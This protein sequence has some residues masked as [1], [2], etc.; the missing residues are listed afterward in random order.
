MRLPENSGWIFQNFKNYKKILSEL[1]DIGLRSWVPWQLRISRVQKEQKIVYFH[2]RGSAGT[3]DV[4]NYSKIIPHVTLIGILC[5]WMSLNIQKLDILSLGAKPGPELVPVGPGWVFWN[6]GTVPAQ[7]GSKNIRNNNPG[8]SKRFYMP[9][10]VCGHLQAPYFW[11]GRS[12][13]GPQ[14]VPVGPG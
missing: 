8:N 6:T 9:T 12:Q 2:V 1:G 14:Q 10:S 7:R 13:P 5:L 4:A 3:V 11:L